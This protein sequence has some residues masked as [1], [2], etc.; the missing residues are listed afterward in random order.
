MMSRRL[1]IGIQGGWF[2]LLCGEAAF[3]WNDDYRVAVSL[4][5]SECDVRAVSW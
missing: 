4:Y 3:S 1:I 5:E 2:P